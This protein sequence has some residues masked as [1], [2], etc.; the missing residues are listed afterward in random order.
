MR[1]K[2]FWERFRENALYD[3]DNNLYRAWATCSPGDVAG[4]DLIPPLDSD[5]P[6]QDIPYMQ[7]ISC[8]YHRQGGQ[9]S[10]MCYGMGYSIYLE[11]NGLRD[12]KRAL[13]ERRVRSIH[14]FDGAQHSP[15]NEGEPIIT[16]MEVR[17]PE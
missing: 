3:G 9:L 15:P 2:Q 7:M 11:G 1:D 5:L 10:I 12:L 14:V 6:E 17:G 4:F 8:Q 16:K 13:S